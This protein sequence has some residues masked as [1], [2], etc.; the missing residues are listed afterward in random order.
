ME[1]GDQA[2]FEA[3]LGQPVEAVAGGRRSKFMGTLYRGC[4]GTQLEAVCA[5]APRLPLQDDVVGGELAFWHA[6]LRR[7]DLPTVKVL[8]VR[9][10][11]PAPMQIDAGVIVLSEA[12]DHLRR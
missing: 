4:S 9:G 3:L 5:A 8:V 12:V 1:E 2:T 11:D 10:V 7:R 6:L